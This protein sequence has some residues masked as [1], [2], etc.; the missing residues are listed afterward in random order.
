MN[1]STETQRGSENTK[2]INSYKGQEIIEIHDR[3]EVMRHIKKDF[4]PPCFLSL[5]YWCVIK[6]RKWNENTVNSIGANRVFI[7]ATYGKQNEDNS[8]SHVSKR[9]VRN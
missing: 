8:N 2:C 3:P 5:F 7:Q 9:N 6:P 4:Q 1:D